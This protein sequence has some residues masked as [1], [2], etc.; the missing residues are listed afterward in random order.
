MTVLFTVEGVEPVNS[1]TNQSHK[2]L[3]PL[4]PCSLKVSYMDLIWKGYKTPKPTENYKKKILNTRKYITGHNFLSYM[5]I[6][7]IAGN[8]ISKNGKII[9]NTKF[10]INIGNMKKKTIWFERTK[11]FS[12]K[13][14][15]HKNFII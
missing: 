12:L 10:S 14:L 9:L 3:S 13:N 6:K 15:K 1:K 11:R 5:N 7:I 2:Q 8:F 4:F